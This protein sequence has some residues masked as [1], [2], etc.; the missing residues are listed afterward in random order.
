[1]H[2]ATAL[3]AAHA[4]QPEAQLQ[5]EARTEEA[6]QADERLA[7]LVRQQ[8]PSHSGEDEAQPTAQALDPET[9][10]VEPLLAGYEPLASFDEPVASLLDIITA[11]PSAQL[12][13]ADSVSEYIARLQAGQNPPLPAGLQGSCLAEQM[14]QHLDHYNAELAALFEADEV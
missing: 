11:E 10:P 5:D 13:D 12:V 3:E 7:A 2:E 4:A 1:M 9:L 8:V 14:A 6:D